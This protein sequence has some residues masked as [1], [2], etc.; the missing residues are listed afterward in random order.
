MK[1]ILIK[2][3]IIVLGSLAIVF[4]YNVLGIKIE[5]PSTF[6]AIAFFVILGIYGR[7]LQ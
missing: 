6:N 4:M 5:A 1:K 3:P 2:I 7:I